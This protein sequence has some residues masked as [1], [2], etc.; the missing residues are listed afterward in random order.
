[1]DKRCL[2]SQIKLLDP[3]SRLRF[4]FYSFL[5]ITISSTLICLV[6]KYIFGRIKRNIKDAVL[7]HLSI[8]PYIFIGVIVL[9]LVF[10]F[11]EIFIRRFYIIEEKKIISKRKI[12]LLY[13]LTEEDLQRFK[14]YHKSPNPN[15]NT[16]KIYEY[17]KGKDIYPGNESVKNKK[18]K[19]YYMSSVGYIITDKCIVVLDS[20]KHKKI[21]CV[22]L[23]SPNVPEEF[24]STYFRNYTT[25][26]TNGNLYQ[27]YDEH[28]TFYVLEKY[29]SGQNHYTYCD[30]NGIEKKEVIEEDVIKHQS[31]RISF[32]EAIEQT[33][34][35]DLL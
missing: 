10:K 34:F 22:K 19:I 16:V 25:S 9:F 11:M 7:N 21:M 29:Y 24:Y 33:F 35:L 26:H 5:V 8:L 27:V 28:R 12:E 17:V 3:R 13:A 23:E 4:N 2:K 1:M 20:R 18:Y 32:R 14:D 31:S 30:K 15:E 6:I